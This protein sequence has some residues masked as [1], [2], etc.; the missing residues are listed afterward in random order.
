MTV[1][2]LIAELSKYPEDMEVCL[3]TDWYGWFVV[4]KTERGVANRFSLSQN[5]WVKREIVAI[6]HIGDVDYETE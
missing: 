5:R 3:H 4:N 6:A 1:A 2:E